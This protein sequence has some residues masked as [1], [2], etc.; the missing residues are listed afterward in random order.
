[1]RIQHSYISTK[2]RRTRLQKVYKIL[3]HSNFSMCSQSSDGQEVTHIQLMQNELLPPCSQSWSVSVPIFLHCIFRPF[4]LATVLEF[5]TALCRSAG[6][7]RF[8]PFEPHSNEHCFIPV[9]SDNFRL[10]SL[11]YYLYLLH[12]KSGLWR[13]HDKQ[14]PLQ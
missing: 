7:L 9:F 1:M 13:Y 14:I 2:G 4:I 6:W 5:H 8:I 10:L 12:S 11:L 3:D